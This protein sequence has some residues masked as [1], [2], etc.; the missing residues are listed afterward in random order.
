MTA[1]AVP[2]PNGLRCSSACRS[3]DRSSDF[4]ASRGVVLKG[5]T[6]TGL[7]PVRRWST[8]VNLTIVMGI[9]LTVVA[10]AA[11]SPAGACPPDAPRSDVPQ[12]A[13][14]HICGAW[15]GAVARGFNPG[16]AL[17]ETHPWG[18][19][20]IRDFDSGYYG[21]G[22]IMERQGIG[23][24]YIVGSSFWQTY[25]QVGGATG[26]LGYPTGRFEFGGNVNQGPR[27][28]QYM[29]FEGGV[30]NKWAAGTFATW[31]AI[32]T[33]WNEQGN[34]SGFLARPLSNE[35]DT[36]TSPN[37]NRGRYSRFEGGVINYNPRT[38]G[39]YIVSGGILQKY[40]A[41]GY[42]S[43]ALGLPVSDERINPGRGNAYQVFDGGV[44]NW[45]PGNAWETHG[46]I[47]AKWNALGG[48]NGPVG[49]PTSD[50][51][52]TARVNG[53]Y[54]TFQG[55]N[56]IFDP[57]TGNTW[58]VYGGIL[59]KYASLGYSNHP[60]GLPASDRRQG[61][62][63]NEYQVFQ[64]GVIN[65][66]GGNAYETHGA[67]LERWNRS[68]GV[69][70]PLG[71]AISDEAATARSPQGTVGRYSRF[72]NG[73]INYN[74]KINKAVVLFGAIK[75]KYTAVGFAASYL[76]LPLSEEYASDGGK[77]QDFEGGYI[78]WRPGW[79]AARTDR[80]LGGGGS[81]G[82]GTG[83]S[84]SGGTPL[85]DPRAQDFRL[86]ALGDSVTA[87]FGFAYA[88]SPLSR[89]K[90]ISA[91]RGRPESND[92]QSPDVVAY[93]G[94]FARSNNVQ[95][96]LNFAKSGSTP[97]D[98][99]PGGRFR[100]AL[101]GIIQYQPDLTV[102]TLGANPFLTDLVFSLTPPCETSSDD[103]VRAC[104]RAKF[105]TANTQASLT[106]VYTTLLSSSTTQ[107]VVFRYHYTVPQFSQSEAR[108]TRVARIFLEEMNGLITSAAQA[109]PGALRSRVRVLDPAGD[110]GAHDCKARE[111]WVLATDYCIHPNVAGQA[112]FA[113]A[114]NAA[115][116]DSAL[117]RTVVSAPTTIRRAPAIAKGLGFAVSVNEA[118]RVL[119]QVFGAGASAV[120]RDER[121][122]IA[123]RTFTL[124]KASRVQSSI[125]LP[126]GAMRSQSGSLRVRL[127]ISVSDRGGNLA[128]RDQAVRV[129]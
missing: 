21:R 114:L 65:Q 91:C 106:T 26:P 68:G 51:Q 40:A 16:V 102:M 118:S 109:V 54:A 9:V 20:Y 120:G 100:S 107:L 99:L 43:H 93:P 63:G 122:A 11:A 10:L 23:W 37:G 1:R 32:L 115:V 8:H 101:E 13:R 44:I 33:K 30:M 88:G 42:A 5:A 12:S 103:K 41:L 96:A 129:K 50:E 29:T 39:A 125:K 6:P 87:A 86:R 105:A 119:V 14:D 60:L 110:F 45:Y 126:Q 89:L 108:A 59:A 17:N 124:S 19:G 22:G 31:G 61:P 79:A 112:Q 128:W 72:E 67:I 85:P 121:N 117:P 78:A 46:A 94:Q 83:G 28:N 123:M 48:A 95:R 97:G 111:P 82:G 47:L 76:G 64:G 84:A 66:F 74:P 80:E 53:R 2:A 98:W 24:A 56:L 62:R 127:R 27:D 25:V 116:R 15:D 69:T 104:L 71:L 70:G 35:E 34:V 55:G 92:C 3:Q 81:S 36:F 77:R 38:N 75:D 90:I 113:A 73:I 58:H 7:D 57:A 52:Q 4:S 49:L 18:N